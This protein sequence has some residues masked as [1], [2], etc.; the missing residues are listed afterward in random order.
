MRYIP[1]LQIP[2]DDVWQDTTVIIDHMEKRFPQSSVYPATARRKLAAL[3]LEV[4]GDEWLLL[5]A[6]WDMVSPAADP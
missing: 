1:V 5:P 3:I 2:E 6:A 4:F